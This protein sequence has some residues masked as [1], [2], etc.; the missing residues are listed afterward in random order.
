MRV[1]IL[2]FTLALAACASRS[3]SP[4]E[5]AFAE[6][7]MGPELAAKDVRLVKG[8]VVGWLP[9]TIKP[10]PPT[11]CREK[12]YPPVTEPI[13]ATFPAF[14][15]AQT[16]YFTRKFWSKDFLRG[17]PARMD[18]DRSMRLAHELTH[19][20]QWQAREQTGYSPF[21]AAAEHVN[22]EDPYLIDIDESRAFSDYGWEQQGAI[23][24]E[25]VCCRAL[26]PTGARTDKLARLV[27]QVFPA[28]A[29]Q[30]TVPQSS[31]R[32]PWSGA[33]VRGICS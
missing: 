26:D 8:A 1:L 17:Y 10:R 23:V 29:R 33:E 22:S 9:A 6:S 12:L 25:F 3:L 27:G 19:V 15:Q 5:Q 2:L 7:V 4:S 28:A 18:L 30:E 21:A 31:I 16:I 14:A 32:V 20:W 13:E 24:E 11:T